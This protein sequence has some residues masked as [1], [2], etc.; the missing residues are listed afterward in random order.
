MNAESLDI[1]SIV[2]IKEP[3]RYAGAI[4]VIKSLHYHKKE[5]G[6]YFHVLTQT[7]SITLREVYCDDLEPIPMTFDILKDNGFEYETP[8]CYRKKVREN[9]WIRVVI[10]ETTCI[11]NYNSGTYVMPFKYVHELQRALRMVGLTDIANNF[12]IK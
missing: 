11:L 8:F 3:D 1:G 12:K 5:E 9:L 7:L 4:G 2:R 6:A 10:Y